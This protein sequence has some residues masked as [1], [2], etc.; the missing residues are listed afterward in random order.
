VADYTKRFLENLSRV[1]P[2]ADTE[3]RDI[4]T[5]NLGEPMKTQVKMLKPATLEAAIDLAISFE[6]FNTSPEPQLPPLG[7]AAHFAP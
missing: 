4:F 3:E 5:N 6:H 2:I 1:Q 7:R